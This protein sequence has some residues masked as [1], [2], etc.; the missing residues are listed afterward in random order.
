MNMIITFIVMSLHGAVV[1][2]ETTVTAYFWSKQLLL[3]AFA[4]QRDLG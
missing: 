4:R 2:R 1:Q 3:F